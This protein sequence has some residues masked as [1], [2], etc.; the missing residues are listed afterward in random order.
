MTPLS[1]DILKAVL[2][3]LRTISM[4]EYSMNLQKKPRFLPRD[5]SP[6]VRGPRRCGQIRVT[7]LVIH[8]LDDDSSFLFLGERKL[9]YLVRFTFRR[10]MARDKLPL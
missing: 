4:S 1:A 8:I 7:C 2:K 5:D 6:F 3:A 9:L 10:E